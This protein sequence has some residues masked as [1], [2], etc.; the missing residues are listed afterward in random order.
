MR[1]FFDPGGRPGLPGWNGRPRTRDC[2]ADDP[3]DDDSGDKRTRSVIFNL[4]NGA[5]GQNPAER[6]QHESRSEILVGLSPAMSR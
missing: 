1:L 6:P 2:D 5:I 3:G 4:L